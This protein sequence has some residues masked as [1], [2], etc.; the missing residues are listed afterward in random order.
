MRL[1]GSGAGTVP[2]P[3]NRRLVIV[4]QVVDLDQPGTDVAAKPQVCAAAVAVTVRP[5]LLKVRAP[6]KPCAY[7]V[8]FHPGF[9]TCKPPM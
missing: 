5:P 4:S 7:K 8:P 2:E 6:T 9:E 3:E 1:P